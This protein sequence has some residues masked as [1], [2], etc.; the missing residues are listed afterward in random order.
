[1]LIY[2]IKIIFDIFKKKINLRF[3]RFKSLPKIKK[4]CHKNIFFYD[5]KHFLY[6]KLFYKIFS[7]LFNKIKFI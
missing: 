2:Y 4:M 6:F 7:N 5:Y 1:M 3:I